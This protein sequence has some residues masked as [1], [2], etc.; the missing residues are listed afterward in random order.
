MLINCNGNKIELIK[1]LTH[2]IWA[3][4]YSTWRVPPGVVQ[5][6]LTILKLACSLC[7]PKISRNIKYV[8][9]QNVITSHLICPPLYHIQ[10]LIPTPH[11]ASQAHFI[12]EEQDPYLILIFAILELEQDPINEIIIFFVTSPACP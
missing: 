11:T 9:F 12:Q 5:C 10:T 1:I 8:I 6:N 3:A 4:M 7:F 2:Q